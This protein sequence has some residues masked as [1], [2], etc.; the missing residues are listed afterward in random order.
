[1]G[2]LIENLYEY[3]RSQYIFQLSNKSNIK[4]CIEG[5]QRERRM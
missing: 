1:M 2:L 5:L 4:G 3:L